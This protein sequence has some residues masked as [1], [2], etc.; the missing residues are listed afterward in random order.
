MSDKSNNS[1]KIRQFYR[2][3]VVREC[4]LEELSVDGKKP[5]HL[6][7]DIKDDPCPV[8]DANLYLNIDFTKRIAVTKEDIVVGWIC[9][10]CWS[11]FNMED[12]VLELF[13]RIQEKAKS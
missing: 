11:E 8:C 7:G 3:G 2:S 6:T 9:P 13:T 4:L 10:N 5:A 1:K 12:I